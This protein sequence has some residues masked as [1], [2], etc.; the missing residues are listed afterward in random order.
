MNKDSMP[1][2][3]ARRS[4]IS[5]VVSLS[6]ILFAYGPSLAQGAGK[7]KILFGSCLNQNRSVAVMDAIYGQNPD[8]FIFLGD[9]VYGASEDAALTELKKAYAKADGFLNRTRLGEINAIWDDYDF[10][11]NDGGGDYPHKEAAERIFLDFW[12]VPQNDE[13][14]G[15]PGIY[16]SR[17]KMLGGT[18]LQIIYLDTRYFR[19]PL[20]KSPEK[21][22]KYAANRNPGATILGRAQWAWLEKEIAKPADIR[23][24]ASSIQVLATS[25]GLEKWANFPAERSKLLSMIDARNGGRTVLLSGD[26]HFSSFYELDGLLELTSSSLNNNWKNASE[27]D[28]LLTSGNYGDEGTYGELLIN[29]TERSLTL[30]IKNAD[31][32]NLSQKILYY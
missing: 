5:L 3:D 8:M 23:I 17:E 10:G 26:R 2:S 32:D 16:F 1:V 9:N 29:P 7:F 28:P 4:A 6:V 21:H 19:S 27:A 13:R 12:Q 31:A 20:E 18:R 14:R 30:S 11:R 25:H 24:I 15:R 22:A